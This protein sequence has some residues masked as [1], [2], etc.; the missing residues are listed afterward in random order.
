MQCVVKRDVESRHVDWQNLFASFV[1]CEYPAECS[2]GL[3]STRLIAVTHT[4]SWHCGGSICQRM[5]HVWLKAQ[6]F[7]VDDVQRCGVTTPWRR[8]STH[9]ATQAAC[10]NM[11]TMHTLTASWS[12]HGDSHSDLLPSFC[13]ANIFS[14]GFVLASVISRSC[15]G[16]VFKF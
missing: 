7:S 8:C 2:T 11:H 14:F 4:S 12:Q 5:L 16:L 6:W 3:R 13:Y 10:R 9:R 1:R 15:F